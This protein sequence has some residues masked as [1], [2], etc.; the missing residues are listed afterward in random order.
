MQLQ[1]TFFATQTSRTTNCAPCG[2]RGVVTETFP[3]TLRSVPSNCQPSLHHRTELAGALRQLPYCGSAAL[4]A[5]S[6]YGQE[7]DR[8]MSL[9]AGFAAH[10]V[11]PV[12]AEELTATIARV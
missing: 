3:G 6:G 1:P 10:L 9:E 8:R 2:N 11:K 7:Q 5:V 4:V 12:R